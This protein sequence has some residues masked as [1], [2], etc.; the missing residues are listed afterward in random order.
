ML[1][2]EIRLVSPDFFSFPFFLLF[3]FFSPTELLSKEQFYSL[4]GYRNP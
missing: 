1:N 4:R 3:L 2:A